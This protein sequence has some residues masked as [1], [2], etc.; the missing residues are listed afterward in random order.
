MTTYEKIQELL[1]VYQYLRIEKTDLWIVD[2]G[3]GGAS[4]SGVS[5]NYQDA[6][7]LAYETKKQIDRKNSEFPSTKIMRL[8][9]DAYD[10]I[11][12]GTEHPSIH[13]I[14]QA[15]RVYFDN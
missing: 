5:T 7:D 8:L 11:P 10:L 4:I 13:E 15:L 6:I 12:N 14:K 9:N 2:A 3:K 1:E